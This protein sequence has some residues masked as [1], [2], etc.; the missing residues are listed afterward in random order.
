MPEM[1]EREMSHP[2][3]PVLFVHGLWLHPTSWGPWEDFI[4]EAGHAPLAPG[5]PGVSGT[6]EETRRDPGKVAG[7]GIEDIVQ[8]Y[9]SIIRDLDTPP[10]VIGHSFGA[11][12]AQRLP[13][14]SLAAAAVAID[15]APIKGVLHLPPSSLRVAS[16]AL[17]KPAH[18]REAGS[19]TPDPF[20][21][22]FGD[23]VSGREAAAP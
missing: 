18:R 12:I 8:H 2:G 17:R 9:A 20:P 5:W 23:A 22:C 21:Y 7:H 14:Q 4:R 15:A 19:P 16:I 13:G 6:V 11:L 10:I 3:S 1:K